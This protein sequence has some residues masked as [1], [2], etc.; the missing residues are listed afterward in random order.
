[1]E[2][3]IDAR[4]G[5]ITRPV[6]RLIL[7]NNAPWVDR[8]DALI[9]PDG[10]QFEPTRLQAVRQLAPTTLRYPGGT[11]ADFYHWADGIGD[12]GRRG[13]GMHAFSKA[14]QP[15]VFGTDEF[16]FLCG[17]L[18][19]EP[20][21][22]LNIVTAD[23]AEAVGWL[24]HV[25][26]ATQ[27]TVANIAMPR[28]RY[29]EL[30]NEPYLV[31]EGHRHLAF[32]PEDY[33]RKAN[34]MM[35]ALRARDATVQLGI[36]L[37]SDTLGGM[38]ATPHSGFNQKVLAR[39]HEA[40]DFVSLHNAYA[41]YAPEGGYP[42]A[43]LYLALMA[44]PDQVA[45][46]FDVT[47]D[48][49]R[50]RWPDRSIPLAVTEYS[51]F[52]ST[53]PPTDRLIVSMAGA[54]Y[55][56]DLLRLF[57]TRDDVLMAHHWSLSGNWMFGAIALDGEKR[58]VYQVLAAYSRLL[59]GELQSV[60]VRAPSLDAPRSGMIAPRSVAAVTALAVQ[61]DRHLTVFLINK[62]PTARLSTTLGLLGAR[63]RGIEQADRLAAEDPFA[64]TGRWTEPVVALSPESARVELPPHSLT[65]VT[66]SLTEAPGPDAARHGSARRD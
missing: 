12:R 6:N 22:T 26:R 63:M 66:V 62:H 30:G 3:E 47:R 14:R 44:A 24:A 9:Q 45:E 1:V 36:A 48:A 11:H 2:I 4:G 21:I 49:L 53:T 38:P 17:L 65:I 34:A 46:D 52:F 25:N 41:P 28:V 27:R 33:A 20:L 37:R 19:A 32:G 31:E 43:A 50:R 40:P 16:L 7:G 57:A 15:V 60:K 18:G 64:A 59:H 56:A 13:Y 55:V 10:A 29:W 42:E 5:G 54:L 39:L 8:G 51:A 35:P 61:R 23:V 58:P